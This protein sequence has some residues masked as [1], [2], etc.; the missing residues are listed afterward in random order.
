VRK[1]FGCDPAASTIA[2]PLKLSP[3]DVVT[4]RAAGSTDATSASLTSTFGLSAN[5]LRSENAMSLGASWD[6]ATW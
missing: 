2:S 5:S 6:V 1:K 4:V 3:S